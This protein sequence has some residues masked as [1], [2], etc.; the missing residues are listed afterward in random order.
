MKENRLRNSFSFPEPSSLIGMVG[1]FH[2]LQ[3]V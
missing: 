2:I 3:L 1:E